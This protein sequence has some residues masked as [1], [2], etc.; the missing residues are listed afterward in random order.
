MLFFWKTFPY[1]ESQQI[2]RVKRMCKWGIFCRGSFLEQVMTHRLWCVFVHW[3][4]LGWWVFAAGKKSFSEGQCDIAA[5]FR[6]ARIKP[7]DSKNRTAGMGKRSL[8]V[9]FCKFKFQVLTFKFNSSVKF[10]NLFLY[11]LFVIWMEKF[12]AKYPFIR[13]Y[14]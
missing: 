4:Y 12:E 1:F 6:E 10:Y 3:V 13:C 14:P 11:I 2:S 9:D 7:N 8:E 5:A